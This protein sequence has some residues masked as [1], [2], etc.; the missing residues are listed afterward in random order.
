MQV[1]RLWIVKIPRISENKEQ[2]LTCGL[3]WIRP[4]ASGQ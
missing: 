1:M 4:E 2:G 3:Y